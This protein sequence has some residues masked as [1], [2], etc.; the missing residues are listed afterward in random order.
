M[1]IKNKPAK[2]DLI[3][4]RRMINVEDFNQLATQFTRVQAKVLT[5]YHISTRKTAVSQKSF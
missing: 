1:K 4:E 3:K 5:T 2:G